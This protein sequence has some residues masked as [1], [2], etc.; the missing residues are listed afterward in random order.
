MSRHIRLSPPLA[1]IKT[2]YHEA[3]SNGQLENAKRLT[4][5]TLNDPDIPEGEKM[6]FMNWLCSAHGQLYGNV[7]HQDIVPARFY[8][9]HYVSGEPGDLS[10]QGVGSA[11]FHGR[12]GDGSHHD[13]VS[14]GFHGH[15]IVGDKYVERSH[16]GVV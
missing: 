1:E 8:P 5:L 2:L 10:H 12:L 11:G 9:Q 4:H 13:V 3:H 6:A 14:S 7:S 15:H 16:Q